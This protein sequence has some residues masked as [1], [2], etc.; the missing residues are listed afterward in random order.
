MPTV[1]KS[2]TP[3]AELGTLSTYTVTTAAMPV[4]VADSSGS[5][6]SIS[7]TFVDGKDTEYLIGEDFSLEAPALGKYDG[8]IVNVGSP[9]GSNR[10]SLDVHNIMARLNTDHRLYPM[11]DYATVE[12][13]YLPVF[14]LE[15]W[16][17][18][19]GI[20]YSKVPGTPLF[21]QSQWGHFGAWARDIT[22]P[23]K[24]I[25]TTTS[26]EF[27]Q[28]DIIENRLMNNI[29]RA[30]AATL[31]FP[32]KNTLSDLGGYLPVLIPSTGKMVFGGTFG[33]Y[34]TSRRGHVTW[35]MV[36]PKGAKRYIRVTADTAVGFT[37]YTSENGTSYTSRGNIP[38]PVGSI[39]SFY[40]GVSQTGTATQ[41]EFSV[42]NSD[43][44]LRGS[45]SPTVTGSGIRDSLSLTQVIYAGDDVGSGSKL[46]YADIFISQMATLPTTRLTP[47][48]A[49]TVGTKT[50]THMVGFSGNVWEH[51]KQYCALYHLDV[52]YRGGKL[53]F[54]PRQRDIKV[55]SS[56]SVLN[57]TIQNR[58]TARNVEVTNRQNKPT[59]STPQVMWSADSVYQV[60]VGEVQEFL[61][62]TE[63]S[64]MGLSQ[65]VCVS[66]I[67]PFPYVSGSGQYVV[68]GSDGYIVSP[69][70]WAD[71]GGSITCDITE[72][73]GEI[74]V[75]IKGPDKDSPRAPYRISEGDA[76]RPALYITGT[77]VKSD[78][79][80]LKVPTGNS[81]AAKDVGVTIDSP[82][83]GNAKQAYDVACRAAK[84]FATPEVTVTFTEPVGYDEPSALGSVPTGQLVKKGGNVFRIK[85]ANQSPSSVSGSA[86]QHN[87][88]YQLKRSYPAIQPPEGMS[89]PAVQPKISDMN[90]YNAGKPIGKVNLKPLKEVK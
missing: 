29:P 10:Y 67:N 38:A 32:G 70:F 48:K 33:L 89:G 76:G 30:S 78:P 77:G 52:N 68:T 25:L 47:Q 21:F 3:Y 82:F 9:S 13:S 23:L 28:A 53:T 20:F 74:K 43:S 62:Q 61:V 73:E 71:Q 6:P 59:G 26:S 35:R 1:V 14:T 8:E 44:T 85:D 56:F 72:N 66:G 58:E 37:L 51:M 86:S 18:Q 64:I 50:S 83:I 55:G 15:Y 39:Y 7:T 4:D 80:V 49:I 63:H 36:D 41:F 11:A 16:T 27:F 84:A 65:P 19:C 54:E 34:G 75:R 12:S 87:T 31:T 81:K 42:L 24:S 5:V 90:A 46:L 57:T 45:L 22:R 40:V 60:A 2:P 79:K 17:Q 88:I 69:T